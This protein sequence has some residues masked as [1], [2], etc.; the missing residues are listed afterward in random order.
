MLV[1]LRAVAMLPHGQQPVAWADTTPLATP[2][3]TAYL[4]HMPSEE[5]LLQQLRPES[6]SVFNALSCACMTI[7]QRE[8][9]C[10]LPMLDNHR[11]IELDPSVTRHRENSASHVPGII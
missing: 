6:S 9:P 10:M 8:S 2:A 4:P 7:S 11:R 5:P 3:V 1:G